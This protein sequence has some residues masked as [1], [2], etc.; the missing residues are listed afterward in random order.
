MNQYDKQFEP[1]AE[2]MSSAGLPSI[3]IDNFAFYY[4]RLR[5]G[6]EGLITEDDICPV[7]DLPD[8]ETL[9]SQVGE[10][11]ANAMS[12]AVIIK[13]NGGLGTSM[14]LRK[15]KSLLV[16]KNELTFL[17]IIAHQAL[18]AG[19]PLV[20]MNSYV[21]ENDSLDRLQQYPDL[22]DGLPLSFLQHKE[23]KVTQADLSPAEWPADPD[24]EWC[25]PGHGDIYTALVT[26]GML[27]QLL[28][29]GVEYAFVSNADN[30]GAVLDTSI[31]GFFARSG[32]PF[33]MEVADRMPADRKGGHLAR[34]K[35][36]RLILRELA[37][38]PKDD[39]EAFQDIDRYR[40]FNTNNLWLHLPSLKEILVERDYRLHLPLIRNSKSVDPRDLSSTPVYQLET[41][42]G[43]AISV[44]D[45]AQAIR[46]PRSRF[47]PVK[48]T[49]DLLAIRSDAYLLTE[50]YRVVLSPERADVPPDVALDPDYYRLVAD[51][52]ERFASG[53][54]SLID[55]DRLRVTGDFTF[56]ESVIVRG[57]V[58]LE[59]PGA[60]QQLV[61]SRAVLEDVTLTTLEPFAV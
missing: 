32:A 4:D 24:L 60:D 51:L 39:V 44:F 9:D 25:P 42:M 19:V 54:P 53:A 59:N 43:S 10:I 13:L 61:P 50:D 47:A 52:D 58:L 35:D 26:S 20:L 23:P 15:A 6:D 30:L 56:G 55:C 45:G 34:Q 8:A 22:N 48:R 1:F 5:H 57:E 11:G 2:R 38:C 37:Q 29:R 41:A 36:G 40:Y 16:V 46:V 33:L 49:D 28:D 27:D 12:R 14:G 7:H 18:D 21:T 17:D 3:F 31:L